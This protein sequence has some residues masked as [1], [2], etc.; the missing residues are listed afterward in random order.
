MSGC[1]SLAELCAGNRVD[2][3]RMRAFLADFEAAGIVERV[4]G[5]WRLTST[6]AA[7]YV[8]LFRFIKLTSVPLEPGDDDGLT[9]CTPGPEKAAAA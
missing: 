5:G 2:P 6:A 1:L 3:K 7:D 4:G 9:H 8:P